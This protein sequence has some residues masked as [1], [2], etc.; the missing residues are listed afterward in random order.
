MP[1]TD[2][3]HKHPVYQFY[4]E[5]DEPLEKKLEA[6][7]EYLLRYKDDYD[8]TDSRDGGE[9]TWYNIRV[10]TRT[11]GMPKL[12]IKLPQNSEQNKVEVAAFDKV[13]TDTLEL[14]CNL[15]DLWN[16]TGYWVFKRR[17]LDCKK[18]VL[19]QFV[20]E[21]AGFNID[22]NPAFNSGESF[23][24]VAH[25]DTGKVELIINYHPERLG[26]AVDLERAYLE[27]TTN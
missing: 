21:V 24:A 3:E 13:W 2:Y 10:E 23:R 17:T 8:F 26:E 18:S 4:I 14:S 25:T 9:H 16:G 7:K 15:H 19:E 1:L 20:K 6:V 11:E 12:L 22:I 27:Y 5:A